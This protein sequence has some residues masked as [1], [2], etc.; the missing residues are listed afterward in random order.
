VKIQ[1]VAEDLGVRYVLEGSVQKSGDK[2]RIAAQLSMQSRVVTF[3][4]STTTGEFKDI[5][6]LQ[7]E[8]TIKILRL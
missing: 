4:A 3:G 5:F 8:I 6:A 1:K 7:D 2:V